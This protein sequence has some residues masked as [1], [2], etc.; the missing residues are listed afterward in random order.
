MCITVLQT[1]C[2]RSTGAGAARMALSIITDFMRPLIL[3]S[4]QD[5]EE[6]RQQGRDYLRDREERADF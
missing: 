2:M 4:M 1:S 6:R 3:G 5:P